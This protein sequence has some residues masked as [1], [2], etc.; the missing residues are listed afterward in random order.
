MNVQLEWNLHIY[1]FRF[2]LYVKKFHTV[3]LCEEFQINFELSQVTSTKRKLEMAKKVLFL[4]VLL[5]F[6]L[7]ASQF[8]SVHKST[9]SNPFGNSLPNRIS[10]N[11]SQTPIVL[12]HGMGDN[13]CHDFRYFKHSVEI[14][15]F[16]YH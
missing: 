6:K 10:M 4:I 15:E 5:T 9:I 11:T 3:F 14:Q 13:C 7:C 8:V 1:L 12:W 16:S 2:H